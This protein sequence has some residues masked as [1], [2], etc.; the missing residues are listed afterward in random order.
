[1][2][3]IILLLF[4]IISLFN[5]KNNSEN[6]SKKVYDEIMKMHD[7]VMP[8]IGE[9]NDLKVKVK[10][11]ADSLPK[12][13]IGL[14]DSL[15]NTI[16]LLT[17]ADDNMMDWMNGFENKSGEKDQEKVKSYYIDQKKKIKSVSDDIYMSMAIATKFLNKKK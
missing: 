7:E 17:K 14:H 12:D 3:N 9:L 10:A 2:K 8:K 15:I 4:C 16:I 13:Q 11:V 5:C 6:D 1:M